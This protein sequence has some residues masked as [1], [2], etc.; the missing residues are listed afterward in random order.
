M[1]DIDL[2]DFKAVAL[3][4]DMEQSGTFSSSNPLIKSITK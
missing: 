3:Y 1:E 2:D 4:S